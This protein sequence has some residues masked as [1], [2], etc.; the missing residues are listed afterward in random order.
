VD[1]KYVDEAERK[2]TPNGS[3][4]VCVVGLSLSDLLVLE[5]VLDELVDIGV[6]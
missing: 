6:I 4:E 2:R 3:I 5:S 1:S